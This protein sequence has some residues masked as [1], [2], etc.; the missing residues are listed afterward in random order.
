MTLSNPQDVESDEAYLLANTH[1]LSMKTLVMI[2]YSSLGGKNSSKIHF[3][4][5]MLAG[6]TIP[7]G[8]N[9]NS[10][11]TNHFGISSFQKNAVWTTGLEVTLNIDISKKFYIT[12]SMS[13]EVPVSASFG[14]I[15][16]QDNS[17]YIAGDPVKTTAFNLFS[18]IGMHFK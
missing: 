6:L 17:S 1:I 15:K 3:I 2:D 18:G 7:V 9:M 13:F 14:Q 10:V 5:G 12:N 16:M 4:V 11:T 8:M